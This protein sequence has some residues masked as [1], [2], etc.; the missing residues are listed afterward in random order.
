MIL[1][2][3]YCSHCAT[4]KNPVYCPHFAARKY[5][6]ILVAWVAASNM[7]FPIPSSDTKLIEKKEDFILV[8]MR[9]YK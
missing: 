8:I 7:A 5:A 6:L 4:L 1:L 9:I 2:A 3:K